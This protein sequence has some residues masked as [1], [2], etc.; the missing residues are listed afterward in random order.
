MQANIILVRPSK[1]T[2][3]GFTLFLYI[4][5]SSDEIYSDATVTSNMIPIYGSFARSR[6]QIASALRFLD[7]RG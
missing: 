2:E 6:Y 7:N 4:D 1:V 3:K 5:L